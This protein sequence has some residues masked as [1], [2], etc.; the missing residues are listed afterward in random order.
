MLHNRF[1]LIPIPFAS[2]WPRNVPRVAGLCSFRSGLV[3]ATAPRE[4][5]YKEE[6]TMA[7]PKTDVLAVTSPEAELIEW[8]RSTPSFSLTISRTGLS[9]TVTAISPAL[10]A[11]PH[12]IN[13]GIGASFEEAWRS[14]STSEPMEG[15]EDERS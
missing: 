1:F 11:S 8:L 7:E 2:G 14:R 4:S 3:Q 9:W 5:T 10:I 12:A 13:I 15:A 6:L